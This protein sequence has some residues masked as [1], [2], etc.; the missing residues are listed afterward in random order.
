MSFPDT[1]L[2]WSLTLY[3]L[4]SWWALLFPWCERLLW[5]MSILW[6]CHLSIIFQL[7]AVTKSTGHAQILPFGHIYLFFFI[8]SQMCPF[9]HSFTLKKF[10][11]HYKFI[12]SWNF[13][14]V[15]TFSLNNFFVY[16]LSLIYIFKTQSPFWKWSCYFFFFLTTLPSVTSGNS[17]RDINRLRQK[18]FPNLDHIQKVLDFPVCKLETRI[19]DQVF[20]H[21]HV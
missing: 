7:F 3:A 19:N 15:I 18:E 1:C 14:W 4:T 11:L 17:M 20:M 5:D 2:G 13:F 8:L 6:T 21:R 9:L 16:F 10:T 12:F